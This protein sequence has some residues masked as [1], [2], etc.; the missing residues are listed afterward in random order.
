[1]NEKLMTEIFTEKREVP[2]ELKKRI[3]NELLKQ[4]KKIIM[5]NIMISLAAVLLLSFFAISFAVI[6][7]G[8]ILALVFTIAFSVFTAFMATALS[9]AAGKYEIRNIRK[10]LS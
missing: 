7:I 1:M 9:V 8:D 3:H 6:F 10:G 2:E 4:E 5:R